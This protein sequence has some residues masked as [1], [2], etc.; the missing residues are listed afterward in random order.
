V[1]DENTLASPTPYL[2]RFL[3]GGEGRRGQT[4]TLLFPKSTLH[5]KLFV[6]K[7]KL[8]LHVTD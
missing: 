7:E 6:G 1:A 4:G 2:R 8:S 3:F 5:V